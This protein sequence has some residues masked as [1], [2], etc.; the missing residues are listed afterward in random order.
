MKAIFNTYEK[1]L[2]LIQANGYANLE[3][4]LEL[5]IYDG[6]REEFEKAVF[7]GEQKTI[8]FILNN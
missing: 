5:L 3:S 7:T 1:A 6:E 8:E 4:F 2:Q